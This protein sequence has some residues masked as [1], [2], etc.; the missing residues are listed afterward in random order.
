MTLRLERDGLDPYDLDDDDQV[1]VTGYELTPPEVRAV[2]EARPGADGETDR[3][4]FFAGR[5]FTITGAVFD[6]DRS[7]QQIIDRLSA[8][9]HPSA[10]PY[11]VWS[12]DDGTLRRIALRVTDPP[13]APVGDSTVRPFAVAW[14]CPS[15]AEAADPTVSV[16]APQVAAAGFSF[17]FSF[18]LVFPAGGGGAV[19]V[20]NAGNMPADWVARVFGPCDD[21]IITNQTTGETVGFNGLTI[22]AGDYVEID[23]TAHTVYVNGLA[24]ASRYHLLELSTLSWFRIQPGANSIGFSATSPGAVSKAE[25]TFRSCYL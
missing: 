17:P 13:S 12:V 25:I 24:A 15:F 23:S 5:A 10:R 2:L 6:G 8:F 21:P 22:A 4:R 9:C 18:P 16:I 1:V 3:S 19:T 20:D 11:M 14:R 7:Q